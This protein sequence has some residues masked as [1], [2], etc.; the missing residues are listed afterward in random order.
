MVCDG[1]ARP[2]SAARAIANTIGGAGS[3]RAFLGALFSTGTGSGS[4]RAFIRLAAAEVILMV[5]AV[6]FAVALSRSASPDTILKHSTR[7]AST[8]MD[9]PTTVSRINGS[10]AVVTVLRGAPAHRSQPAGPVWP[11]AAEFLSNSCAG[12]AKTA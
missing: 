2:N 10:I 1:T 8:S 4:S 6:A 9:V 11:A 3:I 7:E 5:A 12:I